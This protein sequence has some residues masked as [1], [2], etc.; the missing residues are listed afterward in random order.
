MQTIYLNCIKD[1]SYITK[2]VMEVHFLFIF[3]FFS[4]CSDKEFAELFNFVYS[5]NHLNNLFKNLSTYNEHSMA[6]ED[7]CND[8]EIKFFHN[9]NNQLTI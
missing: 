2:N 9:V 6:N 8:N 7:S 4:F 3:L 1:K 5:A